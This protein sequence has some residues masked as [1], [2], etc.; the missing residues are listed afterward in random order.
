MKYHRIHWSRGVEPLSEYE[1]HQFLRHAA[2][3]RSLWFGYT[4]HHIHLLSVLP[5]E[6][7]VFLRLQ[8]LTWHVV[9]TGTKQLHFFLSPMLRHCY[10]DLSFDLK[11]IATRCANLESLS[12]E[13]YSC[14]TVME[15]DPL[16]QVLF[17]TV[18]SRTTA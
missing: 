5:I 8:S 10:V 14:N 11:S 16:L 18:H 15:R 3:V 6:T 13:P 12:I 9:P 17:E 1:A 7:C 4:I 2:R